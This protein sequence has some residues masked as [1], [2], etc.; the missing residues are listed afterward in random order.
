MFGSVTLPGLAIGAAVASLWPAAAAGPA[1]PEPSRLS[2]AQLAGQRVVF[3]YEGTAP[4]RAL[5]RRVERGRAA[6]VLLFARN[7]GNVRQLRQTLARLQRAARRSP[8]PLPLL[9]MVDQEGGLVRRLPGGPMRSAAAVGAT[10]EGR[11]ARRDGRAAGAAL[12]SV[13]ANVDLAPVADVCRGGS[14]LAR[15]RRCYGRRP[16]TV[17]RMA[18]AFAAG[19]RSRGVA[20]ALKHFPG[21]G[22]ARVNTDNAPVS[23]DVSRRRLRAVDE[24][25]FAALARASPVVMLS[26]AIYPA[27]SRLPATF[28]RT[29]ATGE[30]RGRLRFRGVTVSDA[31]DTPATARYGGA[32]G[33]G[34]RAARAGTDVVLYA[35][36][37]TPGDLAA[38]ALAS[39]LRSGRLDREAF[40][41]SVERVLRLRSRLPR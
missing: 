20:P 26:T 35:G 32:G 1:P 30:L 28:S 13:G 34:V 4:P 33:V 29:V 21:F 22:A 27:F 6:G 9:V 38:G 14:A 3:A 8:V 41:R 12:R 15:E 11:E 40:E 37:Y 36:G 18:G 17:T 31:L 5:V 7:V 16:G 10:R 2:A 25:P 24:R 39:R 19:L 23:I